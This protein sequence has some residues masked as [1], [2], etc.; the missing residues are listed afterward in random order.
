MRSKDDQ[1]TSINRDKVI[2][3]NSTKT[4]YKLKAAEKRITFL[5]SYTIELEKEIKELKDAKM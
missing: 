4:L 2:R 1:L 5:E 3:D